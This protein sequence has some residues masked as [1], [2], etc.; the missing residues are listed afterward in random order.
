M[1]LRLRACGVPPSVTPVPADAVSAP[2][3]VLLAGIASVKVSTS[4]SL[5]Q[6]S[7]LNDA[8]SNFRFKGAPGVIL[9]PPLRP[10]I[11]G[12]TPPL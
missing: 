6:P 1:P 8:T 9:K 12:A 10:R 7:V 4:L 11:A 2:N 3:G 5:R